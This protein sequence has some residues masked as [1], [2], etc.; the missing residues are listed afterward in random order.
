MGVTVK[1]NSVRFAPDP[2]R[3]I[4]RFFM[5]G[6]P[7]EVEPLVRHIIG[8]PEDEVQELLRRILR[9][10]SRR[11]RN[12]SVVFANHFA[13][14]V[15]L[16]QELEIP[17]DSL[18]EEKKLV[19]GA[20][21]TNEYSIESAALFNPSAVVDPDQHD[22]NVG[23]KRLILS[24]RATGEG[25]ISS[26]VFRRVI[27][28]ADGNLNE[29]EPGRF[30]D[31]AA[32]VKRHVYNKQDFIDKLREMN[33]Q[34]D[35]V[36]AIMDR[37][38]D[39]FGYGELV[40]STEETLRGEDI[41]YS[42]RKVIESM[43]WLADSH[44]EISFNRD[45]ALSERV[46][47][48]TSSSETNGIEDARFVQFVDDDGSIDYYATY[49]AYN[50]F[51]ILPKLLQTRDFYHFAVKPLHGECARNK[52]MALFP[53]KIGGRYAMLS[54]L[55]GINN[56]LM[57]SDNIN[58]WNEARKI[59]TPTYP[60]ELVKVGN[61]GS[62]IE[63]EH[64]WLV[65]THGIGPVREYSLG[66]MLLDLD[67]PSKVIASLREPLLRPNESERDGYVPNVV[68]SCGSIIHNGELILPY[69]VSDQ[70]S[71]VATIAVSDLIAAMET[72]PA[73]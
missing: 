9:S 26:I 44:Y 4:A 34:K 67:D 48:P 61:A 40:A 60:W 29:T 45:T 55:D 41:S 65:I 49:T 28:D 69:A 37:V 42:R 30:T 15:R 63:T 58:L 64:G 22:L 6:S 70:A 36:S 2:G 10:Y 25:H 47:F 66:A 31:Q 71:T 20:Y 72:Q 57:Y 51:T 68:Y 56:Y 8:M 53:R 46:I 54:R 14:L 18:T 19:L 38:G 5:P 32:R 39:T 7:S 50:G 59:Q 73:D 35:V 16:V 43:K 52:G 17:M 3:I 13:H 24:F 21:F 12:I 62:P 33:I 11:H 1:R 23:Q 27:V